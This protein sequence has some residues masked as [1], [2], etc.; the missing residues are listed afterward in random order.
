EDKDPQVLREVL[1][2]LRDV[3]GDEALESITRLAGRYDGRDRWYLEAIGIACRGREGAAFKALAASWKGATSAA[4]NGIAW[5]L[6]PPEAAAFLAAKL[7][8]ASLG[9]E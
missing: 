8:D 4:Q 2:S 6:H 7:D 1:V 5:E 9:D 3:P